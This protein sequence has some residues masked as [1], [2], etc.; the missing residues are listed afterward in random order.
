[1]A[2]A[3][4]ATKQFTPASTIGET[5]IAYRR[6]NPKSSCEE[7]TQY[8]KKNFPGCNTNPASVACT[9]GKASKKFNDPVL[10]P[11]R[12]ERQQSE[13]E[14]ELDTYDINAADDDEDKENLESEEEI[15]ERIMMRY[16]TM[17]RLAPKVL[18]N[19]LNSLIVS[20]PPGVSKS[21]SVMEAV[22]ASGR[23]RHDGMTDVGGGGPMVVDGMRTNGWYD[24]I[25]GSCSETGLYRALWYQRKGGVVIFDDCDG[26]FRE[27]DSINMLKIAT[28]TTKE[29]L[30][31]WR[32]QSNWLDDYGIDRTFDFK[33]S[34]I[35]LTN[36][37]FEKMIKAESKMT[38]HYKAFIDRAAYLCM[39]IRTARDFM[40]VLNEIAGGKNGFLHD[41]PYNLN[42]K[43]IKKLFDFISERQ[44]DWYNLSLRLVGQLATQMKDDPEHWQTDA[45]ATK[46]KTM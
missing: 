3:E 17:K 16:K 41:A 33:G 32:K 1:M 9:L 4:K 37:D 38:V 40:I 35:F 25:S 42:D 20:G 12:V 2:K 28:D 45:I 10:R 39:T 29:R 8:I 46:T 36:V 13:D 43:E 14:V 6:H 30:L 22:I 5:I 19:R 44:R 23:L 26:I 11:G 31:S 21:H 24:W 18:D 7:I 34:I 27:E 15:R